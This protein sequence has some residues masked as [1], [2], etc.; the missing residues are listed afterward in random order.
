M[1]FGRRVCLAGVFLVVPAGA[2]AQG[3]EAVGMRALGM[4]G[5]FVG[6]ADDASATYWNPAGLVTGPVVS[7]IAETN[8]SDFDLA[9][10]PVGLAVPPGTL[11][12]LGQSGTLVAL[13]TWPIGATYYR[14][15]TSTARVLTPGPVPPPD[16]TAANLGRLTATHLG[17]NVLH[18]IVSGL[19]VGAALKYVHG[20]AGTLDVAP[21]PADPL[22]AAGDLDTRGSSTFDFD[23][24]VVADMRRVRLGLAV[25]NVLEPEFDTPQA[26]TRLQL[27]R[28]VRAG[29]SVRATEGL[30]FAVDADLTATPDPAAHLRPT[31]SV[32]QGEWRSLAAGAEQRFWQDRAAL[33]GGMRLSTAGEAR[34]VATAGGSLMLRSGLFADGFVAIGVDEAASDGFGIGV[35]FTF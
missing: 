1:T 32:G 14:L 10:V 22:D 23:A 18:S 13:G 16:G 35:R 24:G 2:G 30:T 17:V 15:S 12:S 25:R 6:V 19:H 7:L 26:G 5:A 9:P 8:R 34:P 28:Q 4:A 27:P 31:A 3:F 21:A 33:R 11:A 29:G 20:S